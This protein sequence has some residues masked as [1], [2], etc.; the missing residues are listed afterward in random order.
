MNRCTSLSVAFPG[1]Q[2]ADGTK[3][4]ALSPRMSFKCVSVC[5]CAHH[6][7]FC[8]LTAFCCFTHHC[9]V[10]FT[11][12]QQSLSLTPFPSFFVC[13]LHRECSRWVDVKT[14]VSPFADRRSWRG[15]RGR[16]RR[17][18][19]STKTAGRLRLPMQPF[20]HCTVSQ[21]VQCLGSVYLSYLDIWWII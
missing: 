8:E 9:Q 12:R 15:Q 6:G 19:G 14:G 1:R 5:N 11:T 2:T 18:R 10:Y 21:L 13:Q 17:R 20:T 16:P 7:L 3:N 4:W